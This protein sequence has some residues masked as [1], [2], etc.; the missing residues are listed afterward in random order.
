MWGHLYLQAKK[1]NFF[2]WFRLYVY[3]GRTYESLADQS[4]FSSKTLQRYV[5]QQLEE[6]TPYL[7]LPTFLVRPYYLILDG[8][9]FEKEFVLMIYRISGLPFIIHHSFMKKEWGFKI[10]RD[11]EYLKN[12]GYD[13]D[14]VVSDGGTGITKALKKAFPFRP[15]QRCLVH[16]H[17]QASL[18]VGKKPKDKRLQQLKK[19]V[20]HLFLIES[21]ETLI[22]WTEELLRWI[23]VNQDYLKEY[24]HDA[25]RG[26]WWYTHPGVRKTIQILLNAPSQSFVFTQGHPL[27]P[28]ST[29][30]VEGINAILSRRFSVHS[31]LSIKRWQLLLSWFIYFRNQHQ[32]SKYL[33]N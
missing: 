4:G 17:R 5:H 23:R 2:S 33:K 1:N 26:R 15:H 21:Q 8:L 9:W 11:L 29:N 7:N 3:K 19:L 14:G 22:W 10:A 24:T 27:C 16:V 13:P 6:K 31:G 18:G 25:T 28:R 20:D 30:E 32:L 12:L